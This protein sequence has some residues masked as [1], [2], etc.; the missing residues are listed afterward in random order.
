MY[1]ALTSIRSHIR[2][3]TAAIMGKDLSPCSPKSVCSSSTST[4]CQEKMGDSSF[5]TSLSFCF[6]PPQAFPFSLSSPQLPTIAK[7]VKEK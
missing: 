3:L 7:D 2:N 1:V 5:K 4:R 6:R